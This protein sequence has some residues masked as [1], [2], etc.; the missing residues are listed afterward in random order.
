MFSYNTN[1]ETI[2]KLVQSDLGL[3]PKQI[4]TL[5]KNYHLENNVIFEKSMKKLT[6]AKGKLFSVADGNEYVKSE[7]LTRQE[8]KLWLKNS[9]VPEDTCEKFLQND[10]AEVVIQFIL[11]K[12]LVRK[13]IEYCH[14]D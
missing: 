12:F 11:E 2:L 6:E 8:M 1:N 13:R 4:L 14:V 9:G 5:S 10:L 3:N 7:A